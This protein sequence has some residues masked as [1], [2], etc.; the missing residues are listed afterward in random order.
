MFD[1]PIKWENNESSEEEEEEENL[2]TSKGQR[3]KHSDITFESLKLSWPNRLWFIGPSESGKSN[4]I[5]CVVR[6]YSREFD[7]I[8]FFGSN[9]VEETWLPQRYRKNSV[10]KEMIRK[11]WDLHKQKP[12]PQGTLY[13]R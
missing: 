2:S 10:D 4:A 9:S 6:K 5:R 12:R 7:Y 1:I 11:L 3:T 8:M 13:I